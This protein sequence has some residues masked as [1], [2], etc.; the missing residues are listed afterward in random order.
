MLTGRALGDFDTA[1]FDFICRH[2]GYERQP[3][4][5][6]RAIPTIGVGY[7]LLVKEQERFILRPTLAR[8]F[9]GIHVLSREETELLDIIAH[10]LTSGDEGTARASYESRPPGTLDFTLS[11]DP[12][13]HGRRLY[14]AVAPVL[15]NA[16]IPADIRD[17][18]AGSH[19]LSALSSLAYNAPSLIGKNL[20]A[21]IRGG[22]RPAAWFEILYRS[23]RAR[24]GVRP[25]GLH[26]RRVD[27]AKLFGLYAGGD[28]PASPAEAEAV[29]AFLNDH[30]D[31]ML[32]YLSEVKITDRTGAATADAYSSEDREAILAAH[33]APAEG[34]LA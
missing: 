29:T 21:A 8:D 24:D 9:A 6:I 23:N 3:Y 34:R 10:H 28:T 31:E 15:V 18:L 5:D 30:R 26:N 22:N 17:A 13:R 25:L 19:E 11:K 12:L 4:L 2:E 1:T 32:T 20:K 33:I 27:E 16:A 7:A 14:D